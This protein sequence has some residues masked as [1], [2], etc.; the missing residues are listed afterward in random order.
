MRQ[1]PMHRIRGTW[2][3][4]A[5]AVLS[6]VALAGVRDE[7][8]YT[9]LLARLGDGAP[10]GA[11]IGVAHVEAAS[12]GNYLPDTSHSE[13][14][15]KVFTD[16]SQNGGGTSSHATLVGKRF[17]GLDTSIAPGIDEID[18][19]YADDWLAGGM[20]RVNRTQPPEV[21]PRRVENHS[22]IVNYGSDSTAVDM[23]R[24]LDYR[25][26]RDG[27]ACVVGLN[28]GTGA[29]PDG[30]A[31]AYNVIAVG[32]TDGDHSRGGTTRDGEGRLR[33]H[34]VVPQGA[35]SYAAPLV[36]GASALLLEDGAPDHVAVRAML[37]AGATKDEFPGWSR[38]PGAPLDPVYGAGELNIDNSHRIL[39][40]G[41][42]PGGAAADVTA[43]GWDAASVSPGC[44]QRYFID[45]PDGYH[46]ASLSLAVTWDREITDAPGYGFDPEPAMADLDV[47]FH[48]ADG[49][50][51]GAT[52]D[53]SRSA[54]DNVEHI[55]LEHLYG[56]RYVFEVTT[57]EA[58]SYAASWLS[59]L[60]I[61]GDLDATGAVDAAD[62]GLML[63]NYADGPGVGWQ[64]G[65]VGG[66]GYVGV[67]DLGVL[68]GNYGSTSMPVSGA[69]A[70]APEPAILV[71]L[72]G[73]GVL[74]LRRRK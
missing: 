45:V 35:T 57:D 52:L 10:T 5:I 70:T 41:E 72:A 7:V 33:P 48:E 12:S 71:I 11:G 21:Q 67:S 65:D 49:Y 20:L 51:A 13:F 58:W 54:A 42:Q 8:G 38:S 43:T 39:E 2:A 61:L 55:A 6:P 32:V 50:S 27:V 14:E 62:L 66:D 53:T 19:Y 16:V 59:E 44:A 22:W 60:L 36:A 63:G 1:E 28:N 40:S 26:A 30:L 17:Y 15:G 56:E 73:G 74:L 9:E 31:N 69:P 37:L 24:R 68:L 25:I 23:L 3:A 47:S 4:L 46:L 29:L 18:L 64:G 34:M